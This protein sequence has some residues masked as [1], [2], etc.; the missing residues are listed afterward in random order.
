[1]FHLIGRMTYFQ[2]NLMFNLIKNFNLILLH[3]DNFLR[4]LKIG[5]WSNINSQHIYQA[6]NY[7]KMS[8]NKDTLV[9]LT[10][11]MKNIAICIPLL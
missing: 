2:S 6:K 1:M 3:E 10:K 5:D 4:K 7:C 8:G 9:F 11:Y